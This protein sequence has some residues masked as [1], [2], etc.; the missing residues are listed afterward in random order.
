MTTEIE[1]KGSKVRPR[2]NL[3]VDLIAFQMSLGESSAATRD[4]LGVANTRWR[5]EAGSTEPIG[6]PTLS[7]LL[8]LYQKNPRLIQRKIDIREFYNDIG[9]RHTVDPATFALILGREVSAYTRWMS[10]LNDISPTL[11]KLIERSLYL[12]NGDAK[13]AFNMIRE[14]Y[15]EEAASRGV[16]PLSARRWGKS[17]NAKTKKAADKKP[18]AKAGKAKTATAATKKA[19]TKKPAAKKRA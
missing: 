3:G 14:L 16:D 5:S 19:A 12:C 8:R 4:R 11:E 10:G 7:M 1:E 2:V 18:A 13:A 9:G 17:G 15:L 6:D